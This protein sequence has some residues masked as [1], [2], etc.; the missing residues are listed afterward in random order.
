MLKN[1]SCEGQQ[2]VYNLGLGI[3]RRLFT[4]EVNAGTERINS[5]HPIP[6]MLG[7]ASKSAAGRIG[8]SPE[9]LQAKGSK[10]CRYNPYCYDTTMDAG[11]ISEP[12]GFYSHN[13]HRI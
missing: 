3:G 13:V 11:R 5:T 1:S 6:L 2:W 8:T 12:S 7:F 4:E 10:D 9:L